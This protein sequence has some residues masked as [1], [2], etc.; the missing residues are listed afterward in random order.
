MD[1][2]VSQSTWDTILWS[3]K[4]MIA[5]GLKNNVH[6]SIKDKEQKG[7]YIIKSKT[8][9]SEITMIKVII[10]VLLK[11]L[12]PAETYF[13]FQVQRIHWQNNHPRLSWWLRL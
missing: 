5:L 2:F 9:W 7:N 1:V 10:I 12:C 6:T 8:T 4:C 11:E 13:W 3:V